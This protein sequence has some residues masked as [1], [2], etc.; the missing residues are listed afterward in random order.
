[1]SRRQYNILD[2]V[3]RLCE[4]RGFSVESRIENSPTAYYRYQFGPLG[5]ELRRNLRNAWWHDVVRS[6]GKVYGFESA[7][8]LVTHVSEDK[9]LGTNKEESTA[10]TEEETP[11]R[12]DFDPLSNIFLQYMT[13]LLGIFPGIEV[14][15]GTAWSRKYF[16]RPDNDH[17]IFRS[18]EREIMS[19]EFFC[20]ENRVKDWTNHWK[21]QRLVWW[22]KFANIRSNY[23]LF[24][25]QTELE[26]GPY[27][28]TLVKFMFP[29][30]QESV[31]SI[32]VR[33]DLHKY[34]ATDEFRGLPFDKKS[35][36]HVI[37]V[38]TDLNRGFL[39]YLMDAY[40]EKERSDSSGKVSL[41]T[42]LH[43]HPQLA[44]VKVAVLSQYP[45]HSELCEIAHQLSSELRE[46]GITTQCSLHASAN[47]CYAY[48]DEIGTPYCITI[49][50]TILTNG[51]V[52]F[53]S[54]N[55]TLQEYVHISEALHTVKSHLGLNE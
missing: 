42:V 41:C 38:K 20:A 28:K 37:Q 19:L 54:R 30:G 23:S 5:T 26:T 31:D 55:T 3:I 17:Y 52:A 40:S 53:R 14:P 2:K 21:R 4:S 1:M 8:E 44:P 32:T 48:Q 51:V 49:L 10:A 33:S 24:E 35:I 16:E 15:F 47:E 27:S 34:I 12:D 6:K 9:T 25:E 13:H 43:L 11:R 46:A 18:H 36:P 7:S 29:W 50:D 22:R 45:Q 39:A